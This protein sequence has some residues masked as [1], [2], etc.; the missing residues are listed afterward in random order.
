VLIFAATLYPIFREVFPKVMIDAPHMPRALLPATS[1]SDPQFRRPFDRGVGFPF[2]AD[3]RHELT[4]DLT[5]QLSA[6]R[7]DERLQHSVLSTLR[8]IVAG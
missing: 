1:A 4:R 5:Q 8:Q 3:Q 2:H 7:Q 6:A